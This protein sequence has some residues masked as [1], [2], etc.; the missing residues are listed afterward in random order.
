[1]AIYW[2]VLENKLPKVT[3]KRCDFC[4]KLFTDGAIR[5]IND[6]DVTFCGNNCKSKWLKELDRR[7]R[8]Y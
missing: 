8:G 2:T 5:I 1:M 4:K 7:E 3:A 6:Y